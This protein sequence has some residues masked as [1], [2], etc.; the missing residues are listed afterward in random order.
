M[1]DI[2]LLRK[3]KFFAY[4]LAVVV[5]DQHQ[6]INHVLR[7]SDLL[8]STPRQLFLQRQLGYPPPNYAHIPVI[9]N[10]QGQKLSK[11]T[12]AKPLN[13]SDAT[14]NLTAALAFLKQP[15]PPPRATVE[16]IID[17][18]IAHW[19]IAAI[20]ARTHIYTPDAE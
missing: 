9:T 3:D 14:G 11:Q 17:W 7:G 5:D 18:A 20:P 1:G 2:V 16:Q 19:S 15:A 13:S 8:D 12:F 6:Q 4:Q 10:S